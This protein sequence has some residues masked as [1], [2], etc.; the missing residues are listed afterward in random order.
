M[1]IYILIVI[2]SL[3]T[4]CYYYSWRHYGAHAVLLRLRPGPNVADGV[5]AGARRDF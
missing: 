5:Q 3:L 4:T 1:Y 2:L